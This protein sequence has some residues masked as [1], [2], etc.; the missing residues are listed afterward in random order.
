MNNH[1]TGDQSV[2]EM[3]SILLIDRNPDDA[4]LIRTLLK[5]AGGLLSGQSHFEL[6]STTGFEQG[7][8]QAASKKFAA[9]LLDLETADGDFARIEELYVQSPHTPILVL[10]SVDGQAAVH[11]ALQNG[12]Q[13]Y[14]VKNSLDAAN[15][16]TLI[17]HAIARQHAIQGLIDG[18]QHLEDVLSNVAEAMISVNA[19]Q[20]IILFNKVAEQIFGY[21]ADE[22]LGKSLDLLLPHRFITA[23]QNHVR[24]F[25]Q[26]DVKERR[27]AHR[28]EIYGQRKDGTEFPVAAGISKFDRQ[29]QTVFTAI[30]EDITER[31][32]HEANRALL[33]TIVETTDDAILSKDLDGIIQSWNRGAEKL[34]GYSANEI[35]GKP[36]NIHLPPDRPHEVK[37]ILERIKRGERVEHFETVRIKKNGDPVDVSLTVSPV[38]DQETRIV[39]ASSIEH[40]ITERKEF[41]A[42]LQRQLRRMMALREIDRAITASFDV[43]VTLNVFLDQITTELNVDAA[44]VLLINPYSRM[45]EYAVSRGFRRDTILRSQLR[46]GEGYAGR[47]AL[48]RKMINVPDLP[49]TPDI[50]GQLRSFVDE[51]FKSYFGAPLIAKGQCKGVL[52][53][54]N[55]ESITPKA[56]WLDFLQMLAGQ[57]AIAID[58]ASLFNELQKSN[59]ELMLA[60][61]T[62]LEGWSHALDLRDRET[63]GHTQRVTEKT[64]QLVRVLGIRDEELVHIRRGALLH[65][66]GK[67]GIPDSILLKPSSLNDNEWKIMRQH[68]IYAYEMLSPIDYL[69]SALDIPYCHHEK[70]DGQGYPRGLKGEQ[71][72]LS[73]RAFAVVD[74]WDALRSDRPYRAGWSKDLV[75]EHIRSETGKHFDPHVVSVFEGIASNGNG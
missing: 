63:E 42:K 36:I 75:W 2:V 14:I 7:L 53:V 40:D 43:H 47:V 17:Q 44:A 38:F 24:V 4:K 62:T 3:L 33:A 30:V 60:Y 65:D 1:I 34:Y 27:M 57:A 74:V 5:R 41:E 25:G 10:A 70:W 26:E 12:A 56:E 21:S 67:M 71:I 20:K 58:S 50:P 49:N 16:G 29:G 15:L 52:E 48:E 22:V 35:I 18:R 51:G 8:F 13:E 73:A 23:H 55:R 59:A 28:R 6:T 32:R 72:P 46:I 39:G 66:I 54:F 69:R 31:Q 45:L 19:E 37:Q 68:P 61:D 64:M 11:Q 9:I